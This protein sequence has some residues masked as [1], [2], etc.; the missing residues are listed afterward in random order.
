LQPLAE[1]KRNDF[2]Y[3]HLTEANRQIDVSIRWAAGEDQYLTIV[4]AKDHARP[5]D[6]KVVDEFLSVIKDVQATGGILICRSG[7]TK[8][9][10]LRS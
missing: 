1:V 2:I 4:Q 6:I 9:A 7:F 3:G 5:A 8:K 10:H